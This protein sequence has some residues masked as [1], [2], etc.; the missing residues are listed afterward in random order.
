MN[1]RKV[2]IYYYS[3]TGTSEK[4]AINIGQGLCNEPARI[5]TN[6]LTYPQFADSL[7]EVEPDDM[8]VIAAPVYAGRIA[9]TA[10][11]RLDTI[12]FAGNPAVLVAVYGNRHYDDS[13]V[14]LREWAKEAG[15]NPV[16][17]AAFIGE[18][19]YSTDRDPI[20]KGRPD[21]LDKFKA[22][23]F[24]SSVLK[25][26]EELPPN[27]EVKIPEIPGTFPLPA[28]KVLPTSF[29]ETVQER[30]VKCGVCEVVCPTGAVYFKKNYY[31]NPDL[32]TLC[33]ACI[34]GCKSNARV[35][36]SDHLR[37]IR[38]WLL[39]VA[40]ERREPEIFI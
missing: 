28:R 32:C 29:A 10:I 5:I 37:K 36:K 33:C 20:G 31:T 15:L 8:V 21:D 16:A 3:P 27:C 40:K 19:S 25:K 1:F 11:D 2:F 39:E 34:R 18:H 7:I 9:K 23:D 24:G 35:I 38:E 26:L 13:L 30:C 22:S 17:F 14:E 12:K 6:N 4:I